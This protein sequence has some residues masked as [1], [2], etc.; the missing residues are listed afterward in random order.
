[1]ALKWRTRGYKKGNC[2]ALKNRIPAHFTMGYPNAIWSGYQ[3]SVQSFREF[4]KVLVGDRA[5]PNY[6]LST[7]V[8]LYNGWKAKQ[9][10]DAPTIRCM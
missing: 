8:L 7:P 9:G 6:D 3:L 4:M 10:R 2:R 5:G 1:M